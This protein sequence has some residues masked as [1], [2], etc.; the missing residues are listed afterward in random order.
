M[1]QNY[2]IPSFDLSSKKNS[3]RD[4]FPPQWEL[5]PKW[6]PHGADQ[7]ALKQFVTSCHDPKAVERTL[8][9][10]A[11]LKFMASSPLYF[12]YA[13]LILSLYVPYTFLCDFVD[14][15]NA[16]VLDSDPHMPPAGASPRP[17]VSGVVARR[18]PWGHD[19]AVFGI[20]PVHIHLEDA[21]M[22]HILM[23]YLF[24]KFP[25]LQ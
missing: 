6:T 4:V 19:A 7:V 3:W 13:F 20:S 14:L 18:P 15:D 5:V 1:I 21:P 11:S 24:H 25:S 9:D 22:A 17:T 8:T 16:F 12:P 10:S 2:S 23:P